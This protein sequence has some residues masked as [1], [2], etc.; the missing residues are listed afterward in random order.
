MDV[1][2]LPLKD[3][4]SHVP[5]RHNLH[6]LGLDIHAPVFFLCAGFII[7]FGALTLAFPE[8]ASLYLTSARNWTLAHFDWLFAAVPNIAL[9]VLLFAALSPAGA[10]RLG[11]S[12]AKPEFGWLSW[13]AML[14]AAGVGVGYMFY[15]AAEP[16][17]F[18]TSWAGVPFDTPPGE[19]ETK[20]AAMSGALFHWGFHAWALYAV[21]GLSI[22][23]F[24]YNKGLPLTLRSAIYPLLGK[25]VWGWPGD[26]ADILAVIAAV[27]GLAT[28]IGLGALQASSGI[29][30]LTGATPSI[31][32][33][34]FIIAVIT[35]A[36]AISVL[37]GLHDG[38]KLLSN[39]NVAIAVMLLVYVIAAGPGLAIFSAIAE[40][41]AAY[42]AD[43]PKLSNWIGRTD[44]AFLHNWTI[45]YWAWWLSW[46]PFVGLFIARI[47]RGRTIR[48]FMI[49]V[50][51]APVAA[52]VLW[53]CAFGETAIAQYDD[54][55]GD[56]SGGVND[57]S[58]VLFQMLANLPAPLISSTVSIV[59]LIVFLTTSADS[60]AL[61]V[62]AVASGGKTKTPKRQRLFWVALLGV[63]AA[64]LLIGGDSQALQTLQSASIVAALPFT[65]L[66]IAACGSLL[67]VIPF[68][69]TTVEKIP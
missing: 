7:G 43:I 19:P 34:V 39:I 49:G 44:T 46:A 57:L 60:G 12:E 42:L 61:A 55:A 37:R 69:N 35:I 66:L 62:D 23:F 36:A 16:L 30:Y 14:F 40:N 17:A 6:V 8:T 4:P 41:T 47:S 13:F 67:F 31:A 15:S 1:Q 2:V 48:E 51:C 33:Q 27:F 25:R 28:S 26:V 68:T 59:L 63:T 50:L 52:A 38:I 11:G 53:I 56:I 5:G 9:L 18:Y 3:Q 20:R 64:A 45:F 10:I 65:F 21:A 24:A 22:A 54:G 29:A 32:L 58:L